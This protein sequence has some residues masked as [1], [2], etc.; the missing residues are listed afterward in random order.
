MTDNDNDKTKQRLWFIRRNGQVKGPYPSGTVRRFVLLGRVQMRDRI[1]YDRSS[2]QQVADV[3]EVIPPEVRKALAEGDPDQL[4]LPRMR[5]DE[6]NGRERRVQSE[7]AVY[8]QRRKGERRKAELEIMQQHR[9]AK[10]DLAERRQKRPLPLVAILVAGSLVLLAI[11]FGLYLGAPPA[12]PD[13]DCNA[14][15]AP[16]V[17]WRNCRLDGISL[18]GVNLDGA[19]MNNAS[20]RRARLSGSQIN[21]GD[22]NYLD[23]S[24]ADLSY[25]ELKQAALKGAALRGSDLSYSDLS[26]ADLRFADLTGANLGGAKLHQARFG[27]A[28]WINGEQCLPDS[29]GAC[30]V[31]R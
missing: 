15:P 3:P 13:P 31:S 22:L 27:N 5:E 29:V 8:R 12:I 6:R 11:G 10:T 24:E 23:L 7:D 20:M 9:R 25:T 30:R 19:L 21:Q 16:G 18:E 26:G 2:W 14:K 4:L 17:N 1:S 28:I